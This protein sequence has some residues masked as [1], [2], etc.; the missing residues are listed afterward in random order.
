MTADAREA[1]A[2]ADVVAGYSTYI[3]LL[4]EFAP[5]LVDGK[6][7]LSTGMTREEERVRLALRAA[8]RA[9][10]ALVCSGD[11]GVYGMA[12]LALEQAEGSAVP[13]EIVPGVTAALSCAAELGSPLSNDFMVVSLSDRLTPR[14]TIWR[15]LRAANAGDLCLA[16]YNPRS[17]GR[18]DALSRAAEIL[19]ECRGGETPCGWARNVGRGGA[20]NGILTL[21][22]LAGFEAD[23]FCTVFVGNSETRIVEAGGRRRLVTPR[24]YGRRA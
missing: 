8:E 4:E 9:R 20:A 18:R 22:E 1:V 17:N 15:R 10:V 12:S 5:D 3:S 21:S 24:G 13:V 11:A 23:M 14:E 16:L 19:L 2:A 6:E 7:I